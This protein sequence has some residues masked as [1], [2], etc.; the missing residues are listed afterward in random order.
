M[1][2]ITEQTFDDL[3]NTVGGQEFV[4]RSSRGIRLIFMKTPQFNS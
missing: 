3:P 1:A 4:R 2:R